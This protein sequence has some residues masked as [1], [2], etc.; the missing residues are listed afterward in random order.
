MRSTPPHILL[1]NYA[2]LEYLLLR[3][4]DCEFFDD[5]TGQHWSFI[6]LDEAH[7]YDGAIGIEMAMLLRRLKDRVVRSEHG[8][9][10]CIATSATMGG[11]PS[12]FPEA[13]RFAA[14]LFGETFE[15]NQHD[16]QR[17]DAVAATKAP[18]ANLGDIWGVGPP[19]M[20]FNVA[21]KIRDRSW[22]D[23]DPS[24]R[25]SELIQA[26][27]PYVPDDILRNAE[28]A[29]ENAQISDLRSGH[30][31]PET[32]A[33]LFQLLRG[34]G[35]S[36]ELHELLGEK[37]Y[38][39]P[40]IATKMFPGEKDPPQR[41]IDFVDLAVRARPDNEA[42]SLL[43]ARYH[44]FARALEG[45]FGC[46]NASAHADGKPKVFLSRHERCPECDSWILEIASCSRCGATYVVGR[47]EQ[48]DSEI[49]GESQP[50]YILRQLSGTSEGLFGRKAYYLL[51]D[52]VGGQDEDEIVATGE[53]FDTQESVGEQLV[54]CLKCGHIHPDARAI[55]TCGSVAT[56]SMHSVPTKDNL[57]PKRCMSC[58]SR[59]NGSVIYRFLTGQDA[60]VSVLAT[61]LYQKLPPASD[62]EMRGHPGEGRKLLAFADSR[63]DAAFFAPYIERTYR[64]V[65]HRRLILKTL[66]EDEAGCS[67]LLR[68]QDVGRTRLMVQA[69]A[70]GVF[71]QAQSFDERQREVSSWL[72]QEFIALDR[73]LSLEGMGLLQYRLVKP[74]YWQPPRALMEAPWDLSSEEAW[75]LT[76]MLLDTLRHQGAVTFPLNVDPRADDFTPR[77]RSIFV[78]EE[79]C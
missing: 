23:K 68:L 12:D 73:R 66:L 2:M 11:G 59:S 60:P 21:S 26:A 6:V 56:V 58:G 7:I 15:W 49:R 35:N 31:Q 70:A 17:Q 78:R 39:L 57:E 27:K 13:V 3:P 74:E 16:P 10:R 54:V 1:T 42:F 48:I 46:L 37:P 51:G 53:D 47:E 5:D 55:C 34:D 14:D 69:E 40:E 30:S 19:A 65:L 36:H 79:W 75:T 4:E 44:V 28:E 9:L 71:T 43:P 63:Q 72:V 25:I 8:R 29:A 18:A 33:F 45:A 67:G 77:N 32:D 64:Q 76:A 50:A 22:V 52:Y 62:P 41:L 24:A 20:Y 38:F 61:A